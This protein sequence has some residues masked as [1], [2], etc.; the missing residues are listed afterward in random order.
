MLAISYDQWMDETHQIVDT[1]R[2]THEGADPAYTD[3]THINYRRAF[4]RDR[5]PTLAAAL[6]EWGGPTPEPPSPGPNGRVGASY[7]TSLTDPRCDPVEF[8]TRLQD[9]GCSFTRVWLID[10][11]AVGVNGTGQYEGFVPWERETSG[12][13][14]LERVSSEY[15]AQIYPYVAAMN[16]HWITPQL[17]GRALYSWSDR[18]A[19]MLWVPD[20]N[21][22]P[23]RHNRQG[24]RYADDAAFDV[25]ATGG[26]HQF[27]EQFYTAVVDTLKGLSYTVELGNEMPEKALHYRLRETWRR[28]GY[29]G[30]ISVNRQDDTPGQYANMKVGRDFGSISY[31]GKRDLGYIFEVYPDEPLF[32]TFSAF[33]ERNPDFSHITLSSDGCRKSIH[34]EDAYNYPALR[35]VARDILARGGRYEHQSRMKLRGFTEGR[36][37]LNDLET[38]WLRS[39]Q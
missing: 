16:A 20:A 34:V 38:G 29:K 4:E 1:Y 10:A 39:L 36:I 3:V 9:A 2:A 21:L 27:L 8:A 28:A 23:F 5:F 14:D 35:K 37:D 17:S 26:K 11:W 7:Y 25:I 30:P 33:Y 31:H 19:G 12:V 6:A 18:K 24:I 15:L 22:G 32:R 13:F